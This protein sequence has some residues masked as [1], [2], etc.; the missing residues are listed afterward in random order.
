MKDI[1]T[2]LLQFWALII[3]IFVALYLILSVLQFI[4]KKPIIFYQSINRW[5]ANK[6]I[7]I[8][9][10]ATLSAIVWS[11]FYSEIMG[12]EV[13]RLCWYQ[14]I[15]LYPQFFLF[16][17][18]LFVKNSVLVI[19][20]L[21]LSSVGVFIAIYHYLLQISIINTGSCD[22]NPAGEYTA[23]CSQYFVMAYG[24]IT[25]PLMAVSLFSVLLIAGII[26]KKILSQ[27][28]KT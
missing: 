28:K 6:Y 15:F 27:N 19:N 24:Y 14:R 25:I 26:H 12:Y 11:L 23:S 18:A 9:L 22:R 1:I 16:A 2:S 8:W 3:T 21:V 7:Y 20:S 10:F 4:V 5:I 13:C 17:I